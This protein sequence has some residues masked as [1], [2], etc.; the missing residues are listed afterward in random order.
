MY[1]IS[2]SWRRSESYNNLY[3]KSINTKQTRNG[4]FALYMGDKWAPPAWRDEVDRVVPFPGLI[5]P[6][7]SPIHEFRIQTFRTHDRRKDNMCLDTHIPDMKS[8]S[9]SNSKINKTKGQTTCV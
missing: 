4:V 5:T 8:N 6:G 7:N 3:N 1:P 9:N 2:R